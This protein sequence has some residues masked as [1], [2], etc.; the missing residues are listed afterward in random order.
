MSCGC[1]QESFSKCLVSNEGDPLPCYSQLDKVYSCRPFNNDSI[2]LSIPE[3]SF[4]VVAF[5]SLLNSEKLQSATAAP[6]SFLNSDL[7]KGFV[8]GALGAMS[9][10]AASA[11]F[12]VIK[13][14]MQIQGE[15]A[16]ASTVASTSK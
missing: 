15:L 1:A 5:E 3:D 10:S 13:V 14:R 6:S 8:V 7:F 16:V 9:G 4:E 2:S 12:D 11:P